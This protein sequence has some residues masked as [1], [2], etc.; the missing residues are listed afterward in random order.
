MLF[1]GGVG[2]ILYNTN[3]NHQYDIASLNNQQALLA[4]M[5]EQV[6]MVTSLSGFNTILVAVTDTGGATIV[7]SGLF[8]QDSAKA[9]TCFSPKAS[10]TSIP[11]CPTYAGSSVSIALNIGTLTSIDTGETLAGCTP[12]SPCVVGIFTQRGNAF[13]AIYPPPS[14]PPPSL[15]CVGTNVCLNSITSK[16]FGFISMNFDFIEEYVISDCPGS[17]DPFQGGCTVVNFPASFNNPPGSNLGNAYSG[18]TVS[19][20]TLT[21]GSCGGSSKCYVLYI[22]Q[23]TNADPLGRAITLQ[24]SIDVST[25]TA[26]T[27]S[28]II[29]FS[30]PKP[31]AGGGGAQAFPFVMGSVCTT[32]GGCSGGYAYGTTLPPSSLTLPPCQIIGI[33]PNQQLICN[34]QMVYFYSSLSGA[35][36]IGPLLVANYLFLY[37]TVA[38][39]NAA[40]TIGSVPNPCQA[41][42][43]AFGQSLSFTTTLYT[44]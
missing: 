27:G 1:T 43:C 3:L 13:S 30:A 22:L 38:G 33:A 32:T 15:S 5:S 24:P 41:A 18:Y 14:L 26:P 44:S 10:T 31:A 28:S 42:S 20:S 39:G 11:A 34:P 29:Q 35:P 36:F 16:G 6:S 23:L 12:A 9:L 25:N 17:G 19:S 4:K 7:V 2:F 8:L 21:T 37:G 40:V